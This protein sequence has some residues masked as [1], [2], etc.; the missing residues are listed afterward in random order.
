MSDDPQLSNFHVAFDT[1]L[2]FTESESKLVNKSLTDFIQDWAGS[3][4]P[5]ITWYLLDIVRKE[6]AHQMLRA[7][8]KLLVEVEKVSNS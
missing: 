8:T 7:A 3:T 4:H 1:N 2:L 6:R 5:R